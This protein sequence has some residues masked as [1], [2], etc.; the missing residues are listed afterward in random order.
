MPD[1]NIAWK[2]VTVDTVLSNR[3]CWLYYAKLVPSA[4]SG[5]ATIYNG[6]SAAEGV[7]V[8]I[9]DLLAEEGVFAPPQ[10][11]WCDKGLFVDV[12]SNVTGVFVQWQGE[13]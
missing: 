6:K 13:D 4:A 10:P 9:Q 5:S 7:I 8:K 2:W 12:G 3:P 1:K 11:V